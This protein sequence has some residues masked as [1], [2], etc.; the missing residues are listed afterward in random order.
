MPNHRLES[1]R[2]PARY[3]RWPRPLSLK[4]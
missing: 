2:Q 3:A 4:C 1:D